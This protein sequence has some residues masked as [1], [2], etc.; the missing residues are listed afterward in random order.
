MLATCSYPFWDRQ[1]HQKGRASGFR[2]LLV[3]ISAEIIEEDMLTLEAMHLESF[4]DLMSPELSSLRDE[5]WRSGTASP[6]NV[7]LNKEGA[8]GRY[9]DIWPETQPFSCTC[10]AP[11]MRH[12]TLWWPGFW[13]A[14]GF[15]ITLRSRI[16]LEG[17]VSDD[18][19][20][21]RAIGICT[22]I[23]G[24]MNVAGTCF[25]ESSGSKRLLLI[26]LIASILR[27]C[28]CEKTSM[29]P[30]GTSNLRR[31]QLPIGLQG[32]ALLDLQ[33]TQ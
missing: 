26:C 25:R 11:R 17:D 32:D 19:V 18:A 28:S 23:V 6:S 31:F 24:L 2:G 9:G 12:R 16:V 33:K 3:R 13:W 5:R 8:C 10:R 7:S 4:C 1:G 29:S 20:E 27:Q 30:K 15:E 22:S 14:S 21:A